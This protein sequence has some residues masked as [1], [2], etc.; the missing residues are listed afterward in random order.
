MYE[1]TLGFILA[2]IFIAS[3]LLISKLF[4]EEKPELKGKSLNVSLNRANSDRAI[5]AGRMNK[6]LLPEKT[7]KKDLY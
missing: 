1:L 6:P 4:N 3:Y 2:A 5:G 7:E